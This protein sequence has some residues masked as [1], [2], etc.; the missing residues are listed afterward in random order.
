MDHVTRNALVA[1]N[2]EAK[3]LVN[4]TA[5]IKGSERACVKNLTPSEKKVYVREILSCGVLFH[6]VKP[7]LIRT[8]HY[9]R[10]FALSLG[11]EISYIF[12]KFNPLNTD[13]PFIRTPSMVPSPFALTGCGC[14]LYFTLYQDGDYTA[15]LSRFHCNS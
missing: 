11:K 6:T 10:Q 14:T 8:L 4:L 5:W 9:Y 15:V 12:F 1:R 13:T 2:N 7:R 3:G